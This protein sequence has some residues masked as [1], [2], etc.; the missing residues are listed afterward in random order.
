MKNPALIEFLTGG[1]GVFFF[2][3]F[4]DNGKKYLD[5]TKYYCL[6]YVVIVA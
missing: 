1:I 6:K 3:F 4:L 2:F 5:V